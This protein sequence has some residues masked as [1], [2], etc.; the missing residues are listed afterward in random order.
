MDAAVILV[1]IPIAVYIGL[2]QSLKLT[3]VFL[4]IPTAFF[5]AKWYGDVAASKATRE[6]EEKKTARARIDAIQSLL[7]EVERIRKLV[8]HNSQLAPQL[9]SQPIARMPVAAFETVFVTGVGIE[10]TP[11]LW[12]VVTDYLTAANSINLLAEIYVAGTPSGESSASDRM[13][14]AVKKTKEICANELPK[15]LDR[16]NESLQGEV[17]RLTTSADKGHQQIL[18]RTN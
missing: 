13:R 3:L 7:N 10:F 16:L 5:T 12:D 14:E 18:K 4:A 1:I 2:T 15:V 8:K 9:W 11:E 6:Y 17:K